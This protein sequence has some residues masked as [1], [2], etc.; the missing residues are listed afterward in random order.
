MKRI[1]LSEEEKAKLIEEFSKKLDTTRVSNGSIT[2]TAKTNDVKNHPKAVIEFTPEAWSKMVALVLNYSSEIGWHG[3]VRREDDEVGDNIFVVYDIIVYKQ[4]VTGTTVD[5][6]D[7]TEFYDSLTDEQINNMFFHGHSH[8]NMGVS[9]SATDLNHRKEILSTV[10][11][12]GFYIFMII[13]KKMEWTAVV[14]DMKN[15]IMYEKDDVELDVLFEDGY[16]GDFLAA[17]DEQVITVAKKAK[18]KKKDDKTPEIPTIPASIGTQTSL[19]PSIDDDDWEKTYSGSSY[20]Y[21][22]PKVPMYYYE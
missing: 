20:T 2:L 9:P 5:Q 15:N 8:V 7:E 17:A 1:Y 13:N 18:A 12:D 3:L 6:V 21:Y 4:E 22:P 19:G 14:Y 10:K 16:L 11:S